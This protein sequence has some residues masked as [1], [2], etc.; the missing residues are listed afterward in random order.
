MKPRI[1]RDG[2][3]RRKASVVPTAVVNKSGKEVAIPRFRD[4]SLSFTLGDRF[5]EV[6]LEVEKKDG[7]AKVLVRSLHARSDLDHGGFLKSIAEAWSALRLAL[8]PDGAHRKNYR[9]VNRAVSSLVAAWRLP[10]REWRPP[11]LVAH[12]TH[13]E[14]VRKA[15]EVLSS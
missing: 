10:T 6:W 15:E 1:S 14:D 12:L 2:K 7:P 8:S 11:E 4:L 9:A 5:A 13:L 3:S